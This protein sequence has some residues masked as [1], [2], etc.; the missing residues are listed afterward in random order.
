MIE[1]DEGDDYCHAD[2]SI[3]DGAGSDGT[4]MSKESE[5]CD[6]HESKDHHQQD[7]RG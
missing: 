1:I 4:V 2:N 5:H 7:V 3:D 6:Q